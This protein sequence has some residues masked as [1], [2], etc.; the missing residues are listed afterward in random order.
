[1]RWTMLIDLDRCVGCQTCVAACKAENKVPPSVFKNRTLDYE[2][3]EFPNVNRV[4]LPVLCNHCENAACEAACPTEATQQEG[5]GAITVDS[6]ECVG[7]KSCIAA[8][9]YGARTFFDGEVGLYGEGETTPFEQ[10][11]VEGNEEDTVIK[12]DFCIERV[13]EG[14]KEGLTLG[15]DQGAIPICV[16]AC[17]TDAREFG[18]L[19][20]P[21]DPVTRKIQDEDAFKLHP[22]YDTDP[23][24]YYLR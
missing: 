2:T 11:I 6:E 4:Y 20:D 19:D 8:C 1:M 12:C 10:M 23:Q 21:V 5:N 14:L 7:C 24:V 9:P 22:E 15:E 16:V 18:D 3:G 17:P 13:E